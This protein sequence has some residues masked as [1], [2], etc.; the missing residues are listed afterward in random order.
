MPSGFKCFC[1]PSKHSGESSLSPNE[2]SSS[3]TKI[4]TFSGGSKYRISVEIIVISVCQFQ[5]GQHWVLSLCIYHTHITYLCRSRVHP[6][7]RSAWQLH[8]DSFQSHTLWPFGWHYAMHW[9]L[10]EQ[11]VH[12]QHQQPSQSPKYGKKRI[13]IKHLTFVTWIYYSYRFCIGFIIRDFIHQRLFDGPLIENV[14]DRILFE[15]IVCVWVQ[16]V[17]KRLQWDFQ[18][19]LVPFEMT[20]TWE[21]KSHVYKRCSRSFQ[22]KQEKKLKTYPAIGSFR[23]SLSLYKYRR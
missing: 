7:T 22:C 12:D 2:P 18:H 9:M 11:V 15:H 14:F 13:C 6:S 23:V 5:K 16:I 19:V 21:N 10:N 4:S 3:E 20:T 1:A 17:V 8:L